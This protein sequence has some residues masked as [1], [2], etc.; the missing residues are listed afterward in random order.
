MR[1][2]RV[3]W[4]S[5][6]C[7]AGT[8]CFAGSVSVLRTRHGGNAMKTAPGA[9]GRFGT[10]GTFPCPLTIDAMPIA[11]PINVDTSFMTQ[12]SLLCL[13]THAA[14]RAAAFGGF[15]W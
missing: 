7:D 11:H 15:L 3:V 10:F 8:G 4:M 9:P 12:R 14:A 2:H 13:E 1:P 5:T 6:R